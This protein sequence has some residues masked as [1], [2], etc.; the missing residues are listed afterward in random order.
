MALCLSGDLRPPGSLSYR[1]QTDL[2]MIRADFGEQH[3]IVDTLTFIPPWVPSCIMIGFDEASA[4]QVLNDEYRAWDSLNQEYGVN[5]I[6]KDLLDWIHV[7]VLYFDGILHPKRLGALYG[8]LPGVRYVEP[9]GRIGDWSNIYPRLE[10]EQI[11]YLFR[12]GWGDCPSGCIHD[13]YWYFTFEE[14]LPAFRGTWNPHQ[15][16][17]EPEWWTEAARNEEGYRNW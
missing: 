4:Q 15:T 5:E 14:G 13:E 10:G 12:H 8:P 2:T 9:N 16:P 11:T 6:S 17:E 7:A 1:V 3:P